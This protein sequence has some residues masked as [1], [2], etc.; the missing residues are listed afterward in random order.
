MELP[1]QVDKRTDFMDLPREVRDMIYEEIL[2]PNQVDHYGYDDTPLG[3]TKIF[4]LNRQIRSEALALLE[5][6]EHA[7]FIDSQDKPLFRDPFEFGLPN[8]FK[9]SVLFWQCAIP[10]QKFCELQVL[11]LQ[12]ICI[13]LQCPW[14]RLNDG[15]L[16]HDMNISKAELIGLHKQV[17]HVVE[18]LRKSPDLRSLRLK[19]RVPTEDD[20]LPFL[21]TRISEDGKPSDWTELMAMLGP[22]PDDFAIPST[23]SALARLVQLAKEKRVTLIIETNGQC[24]AG[25]II[26]YNYATHEPPNIS[27]HTETT[28]PYYLETIFIQPGQ[29]T[30]EPTHNNEAA[31]TSKHS[32]GYQLIPECRTCYAV[33]ASQDDLVNHLKDEYHAKKFEIQKYNLLFSRYPPRY[34]PRHVCFTCAMGFDT[35]GAQGKHYERTGHRRHTMIPRWV[36]PD[37]N[38]QTSRLFRAQHKS[39]KARGRRSQPST[40]TTSNWLNNSAA[41]NQCII[42][43]YNHKVSECNGK[44]EPTQEDPDNKGDPRYAIRWG[45][46]KDMGPG[47]CCRWVEDLSPETVQDGSGWADHSPVDEGVAGGAV[48]V[49][50]W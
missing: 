45:Y 26:C 3:S 15:H 29:N 41:D 43:R 49:G 17:N 39:R 19:L 18:A 11:R 35:Q 47:K 46:P 13:S 1:V 24:L 30:Q 34:P 6:H 28:T 50:F 8:F 42:R 23:F 38:E 40:P 32:D 48:A 33:F 44:C 37:Q 16:W 36:D 5:D 10:T 27:D 2:R 22:T 21:S 9:S 20:V 25:Q 14:L 12:R 31:G 4:V 7:I